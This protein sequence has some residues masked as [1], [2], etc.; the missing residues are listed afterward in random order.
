[1]YVYDLL[2]IVNSPCAECAMLSSAGNTC[3]ASV[4]APRET[5]TEEA[6]R[7]N[8]KRST[9]NGTNSCCQG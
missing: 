3:W 8:S 6:R 7:V 9:L 5:T 2:V 1:M 4:T